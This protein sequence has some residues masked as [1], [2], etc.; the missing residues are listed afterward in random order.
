MTPTADLYDVHGE[1]LHVCELPLVDLGGRR[2]VQGAIATVKCHED[3]SKVRE[4]V[5]EPGAGR[6]LVVDGGG[7]RRYALLG[8]NLAA[9]ALANGW[10]GV[11]VHG[12]IRDAAIIGQMDLWVRALGTVPR[13]TV[14]RGGG[15]RDLPVRFGGA[16]FTP[17]AE[18]VADED[19][20]VVLP[21]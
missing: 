21:G 5:S 14:K 15:H 20:V 4:A 10:A 19:G 6:V 18:L 1:A 11:L 7:S 3:N 13:K 12:V 17:G 16:V 8:D 2:Q 9:K